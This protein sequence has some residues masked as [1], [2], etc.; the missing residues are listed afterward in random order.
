MLAVLAAGAG[1]GAAVAFCVPLVVGTGHLLVPLFAS[2]QSDMFGEAWRAYSKGAEKEYAAFKVTARRRLAGLGVWFCVAL[3]L[4]H[5]EPHVH[6]SHNA[7]KADERPRLGPFRLSLERLLLAQQLPVV[8][9]LCHVINIIAMTIASA[10][11]AEEVRIGTH[12][13]NLIITVVFALKTAAQAFVLGFS[14]FSASWSRVLEG[15]VT[16]ISL[17]R[18]HTALHLRGVR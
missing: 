3:R 10:G 18:P 9:A 15:I 7:P 12:Y 2:M 1:R 6:H 16:L 4:R 8:L 13:V 14:A 17:V 11:M 5:P